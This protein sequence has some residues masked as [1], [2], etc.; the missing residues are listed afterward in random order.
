MATGLLTNTATIAPPNGITDPD[1]NNNTAI[2]QDTITAPPADLV[3]TKTD[4]A[5]S[6]SPGGPISYVIVV[7]NMGPNPVTGARV[8]DI[9]PPSIENPTWIASPA[10]GATVGNMTGSGNIDQLINLPLTGSVTY[11]VAGTISNTATGTL[12][13][14]ATVT[15]PATVFDP[16]TLNNSAR[17]DSNLVPSANLSITKT[18]NVTTASPGGTVTYTIAVTKRSQPRRRRDGHGQVRFQKFTIVNYTS[19]VCRHCHRQ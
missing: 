2:D 10:G 6:R 14:T 15:A 12:S 11:N 18:D 4:N 13:N 5:T 7:T 8:M 16:N 17:D 9:F 19:S 3:I 1:P